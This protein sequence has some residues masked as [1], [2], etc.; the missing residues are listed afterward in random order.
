LAISEAAAL[1]SA[2]RRNREVLD[3]IERIRSGDLN[4]FEEIIRRHERRILGMAIQMGLAPE[5]AQDASQEV[6][7]RVFRYLAGFQAGK[8]F[9]VW[10]WKIA[11]NV[12]YD[13]LRRRRD[14]GEVSWET[15]VEQGMEEP[16]RVA[17]LQVRLENADLCDRLLQRLGELSKQ[18]RM[19]FVLRELQDLETHEVARAMGISAITVRRHC[20][21]ARQKLKL[22]LEQ[23][24]KVPS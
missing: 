24:Q 4:A 7:I 6:F 1:E 19:V 22:A 21:S 2:E 18:E 16:V 9:D 23:L 5:D 12:V 14:R 11:V 10:I 8:S 3:L 20:A 13:H 15:L 17:G